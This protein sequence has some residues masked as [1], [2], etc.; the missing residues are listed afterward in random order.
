M[1]KRFGLL[2]PRS[3]DY[4][5]MGYEIM[6][7]LSAALRN[8]G[9]E[10][11]RLCT[12]NIGFGDDGALNYAKAEKLFLEENV[13]M[14]IAYCNPLNAEPLYTL[15]EAIQKPLII[16]DAG[17]QFPEEHSSYAYHISLQGV[18][19]CRL[20]GQMAGSGNRKVLMATSFYD[21]GY[22]GPWGYDRGLSEA[23][24]SICANYISAY[25]LT[26]FTIEPYLG[27]LHQSG[28]T[29]VAA[30][31]SSYLAELFFKALNEKK[32]D[33]LPLPF[34]CS[35]Y[36]AEEQ[37]LGKC[38]FPGGDFYAVVPWALGLDND[39]QQIFRKTVEKN[40][41]AT[42]FHLLGW[43]AGIVCNKALT[44][45]IISLGGFSYESPRGQVHIHPE[46][47]STYAPLYKGKITGDAAGMCELEIIEQ[48]NIEA[49]DH[50]KVMHDKP[51][52]MASGWKNNYLCI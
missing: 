10:N 36:M 4:P 8:L 27:M 51:D 2:L 25:K 42:I 31:F 12:E 11:F 48:I 20:A 23:G 22:R 39:Q 3:T 28:A 47:H 13:E 30:C 7:G 38:N 34:Y 32:D 5:A 24:G 19:A 35:P 21:G 14:I 45:G 29:S 1:S 52:E 41:K 50:E 9:Y 46:T 26:E 16:L 49:V 18:H 6:E 15:A 40:K 17:M 44:D 43:E 37:L 33:A